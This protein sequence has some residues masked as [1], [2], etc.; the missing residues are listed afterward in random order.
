MATMCAG[1]LVWYV[2]VFEEL[3]ENFWLGILI[4]AGLGFMYVECMGPNVKMMMKHQDA[5]EKTVVAL[6][7]TGT[8][9]VAGV[10]FA[11]TQSFLPY[12]VGN[13]SQ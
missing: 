1:W 11:I 7:V 4:A 10:I 5:L 8:F 6:Q 2:L 3:P 12:A 9:F 13:M